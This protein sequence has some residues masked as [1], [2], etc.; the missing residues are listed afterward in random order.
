MLFRSGELVSENERIQLTAGGN[1][2]IAMRLRTKLLDLQYTHRNKV[3]TDS[4]V[5]VHIQC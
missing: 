5:L 3:D 2:E 4:V 1:N